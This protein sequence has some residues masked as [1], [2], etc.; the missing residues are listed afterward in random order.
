MT[1]TAGTYLERIL[2]HKRLEIEERFAACDMANLRRLAER[3]SH[4]SLADALERPGVQVI[5][6]IKRKSP[7]KGEFRAYLDPVELA[8][9]YSAGGAAAVSV[10]TDHEFFGG[11]LQ[12]LR[13]VSASRAHDVGLVVLQKEFI[14]DNR[15]I[16][17]AAAAGADAVLLIVAALSRGQ[18]SDLHKVASDFGLEALVEVHDEP[19]LDKAM[20]SEPRIVGVNSRNLRTFQ[21]DLGVAE[22]LLPSIPQGCVRVAESGITTRADVERMGA[23]GA[24]AVLIGESLVLAGD[25]V[26]A[27]R[28]LR[29]C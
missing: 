11:S 29:G 22:Q 5:A 9:A 6:E 24:D 17:E 7:S 10:L 18:L 25:P 3:R 1:A 2:A 14:I 28:G 12:D 13:D 4:L 27:L 16:V 8:A 26:A 23:A 20:T 19:E 21:T 15:Q